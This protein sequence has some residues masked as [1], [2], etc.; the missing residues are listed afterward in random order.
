MRPALVDLLEAEGALVVGDDVA[1]DLV[2]ELGDDVEICLVGGLDERCVAGA[3]A[4]RNL[5]RLDR[6]DSEVVCP[7]LVD[8]DKIGT[9]V[10]DE[11]VL[12]SGIQE[13]LVWMW[14]LLS[15]RVGSRL[16]QL[17]DFGLEKL[18]SGGICSVPG[19]KGR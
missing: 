15:L 19:S 8:A 12:A 14:R 6:S 10:G 4:G 9:Q 5:Q 3:A 17:I 2:G 13:G 18:Q 16:F 7:C 1:Q 11:D